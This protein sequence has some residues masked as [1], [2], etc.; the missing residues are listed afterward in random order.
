MDLEYDQS[1]F[2]ADFY[3]KV[4][5]FTVILQKVTW[6]E[7]RNASLLGEGVEEQQQLG[8]IN[9]LRRIFLYPR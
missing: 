1:V 9:I 3:I 2:Y 4:F 8:V 5:S 6:K 7:P